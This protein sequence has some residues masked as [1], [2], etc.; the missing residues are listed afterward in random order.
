M[1]NMAGAVSKPV[2]DWS[3]TA[4]L[5]SA[6]RSASRVQNTNT[7]GPQNTGLFIR[8][9]GRMEGDGGGGERGRGEGAFENLT[10]DLRTHIFTHNGTPHT[11]H[12]GGHSC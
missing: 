1:G 6:L 12:E 4:M 5:V 11:A 2:W 10:D 9:E 8:Q 7:N 3:A